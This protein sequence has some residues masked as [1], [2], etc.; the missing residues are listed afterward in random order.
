[1]PMGELERI[2]TPPAGRRTTDA[3]RER[4]VARLRAA[5]VDGGLDLDELG[6]R[7]ELVYRARTSGELDRLTRDLPAGPPDQ[8]DGTERR[9]RSIWRN[10]GFRLHAVAYGLMNGFLVGTWYVTD[11]EVFWPFFPAA[12]WGV[13]LGLHGSVVAAYEQRRHARVALRRQRATNAVE[14]GRAALGS[15]RQHRRAD[16]EPGARRDSTR[17]VAVLFTD[18]VGSTQLTAALGD[19]AWSDLRRRYRQTVGTCLGAHGGTEVNVAGDGVL[20][21]FDGEVAAVRCAVDLQRALERQR[22]E[23]GFALRVRIGVHAGDVVDDDGDLVGHVVNLAS[24]VTD[25]ADPDEV[26]VTEA[27][28]ERLGE[29]IPLEDRGL[30]HLKGVSGP[31]HLL[32]VR[33]R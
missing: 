11:S 23:T 29:H 5:T 14:H 8:P 20:A 12:G 24:R 33:W 1:M 26:L 32:A 16:H 18:V 22:Q 15:S 7:I 28:A 9:R 30:R 3:E 21:C 17:R 4:V 2:P 19:T 6:Q 10:A 27:V 31:R 25:D 13:A